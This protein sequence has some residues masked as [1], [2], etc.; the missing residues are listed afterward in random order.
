[1]D[2]FS[3]QLLFAIAEVNPE[4]THFV[5][6]LYKNTLNPFIDTKGD[7]SYA[8]I[9]V[10]TL[11][12]LERKIEAY[13]E[14]GY[15]V[16]LTSIVMTTR[17]LQSLLMLDFSVPKSDE[18]KADIISKISTFNTSGDVLYKINGWLIETNTS[19]HFLGKHTT[20]QENFRNFLGSSLLFRHK[21]QNYFIVDDRWLGHQLKKGY[22]SIRI[23]HK[24]RGEFPKV[25]AEI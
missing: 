10:F 24:E 12:D 2:M 6:R 9:S 17:G 25:V 13:E 21:D 23:G 3:Y 4:L 11:D 18:A 14:E 22:G 16:S 7:F 20:S 19:Y 1:M 15:L 8:W 5:L